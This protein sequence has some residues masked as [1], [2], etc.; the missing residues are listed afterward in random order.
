[1][2]KLSVL[3]STGNLGDNIIE[4]K[5]FYEGLKRDIDFFAAD[6]GTADAGPTFL[7]A[8]SAHNPRQW[9]EHDLELLLLA[10]RERN[11]PMIIGSCSTTG[12]NRGVDLYAEIIRNLAKKHKLKPLKMALIYSEIEAS[13]LS[14]RLKNGIIEA[15]DAHDNLKQNDIDKTN[16]IVAMMGIEQIIHALKNDADVI[17]AGRCCDD[18]VIAAYPIYKGFDKGLSLHMGKASECA[19]LVCWPQKIKESILSTV[20]DNYFEIEPM[21]PEQ[22]ATPHSLAAHSMYERTN[23]FFQK[24]PGG[25]L[26]MQSTKYIQVS[27]RITRVENSVFIPEPDNKYKVKIEG[28]GYVGERVYHIVGVRDVN[29]IKNIDKIIEDTYTKVDEIMYPL[30]N[31]VD[32]DLY[33]HTYGKNAIMKDI[34]PQKQDFKSHELCIVIEAVSKSIEIATSVVKCAKFRFFYMSYPGQM[35]SSGG[36]VALLTDEPLYPKNSCYQWTINHLLTLDDPLDPEIFKFHFETV[37]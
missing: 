23:P 21:H 15:L 26:D 35:N 16:T 20:T 31:G 2:K 18:A 19:S 10:S 29:A 6:A 11:V 7:G 27:N 37:K 24:L 34:E 8:D 12:T 28:A 4:K 22:A 13:V 3:V 30:K 33:I 17:L 32:F 14:K 5:S 25:T 9:E 1:M 36:A